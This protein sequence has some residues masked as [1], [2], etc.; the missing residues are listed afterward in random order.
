MITTLTRNELNALKGI[1]SMSSAGSPVVIA[2]LADRVSDMLT[3]RNLN[4]ALNNLLGYGL[5]SMI[6]QSRIELAP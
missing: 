1:R 6:D 5:I 2:Q 4:D 3:S